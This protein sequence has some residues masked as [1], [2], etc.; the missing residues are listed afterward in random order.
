MCNICGYSFETESEAVSCADSHVLLKDLEIF[1][2]PVIN[3][4]D[5]A[6]PPGESFPLL[7][8]VQKKGTS[9]ERV[10]RLMSA[11]NRKPNTIDMLEPTIKATKDELEKS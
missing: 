8:M 5:L 11:H 4:N 10:Y 3:Q 9:Q 2:I 6:Y 1:N 7:L